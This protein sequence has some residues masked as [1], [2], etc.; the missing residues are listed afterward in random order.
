MHIVDTISNA[1]VNSLNE[2]GSHREFVT[3]TLKLMVG[4]ANSSE[5]RI[6]NS[7]KQIGNKTVEGS[8][9]IP[10]LSGH[11]QIDSQPAYKFQVCYTLMTPFF[12]K[13]AIATVTK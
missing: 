11:T 4:V 1:S 12:N 13:A 5:D 10:S 6:I 8:F 2:P 9:K 3:S 7:S